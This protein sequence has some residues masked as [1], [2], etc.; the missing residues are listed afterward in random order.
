MTQGG[1]L[2]I[3][4]YGIGILPLIK[5]TKQEIPNVTHPCYADDVGD[6]GTFA[7][8]EAYFDF[9]TRQGPGQ[10]YHPDPTK[11]VLI[12]CP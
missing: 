9:L 12:V 5:N 1:H 2:A 4:A 10:I 6:L 7:R 3:I 8:L 11:I